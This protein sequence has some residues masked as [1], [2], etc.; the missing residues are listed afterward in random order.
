MRVEAYLSFEGRCEEALEFYQKAIGA[1]V[2]MMMRMNEN[3]EPDAHRAV[4]PGAEKK[5]LHAGFKVG[6]TLLM[7]SDG[8]CAGTANFDG[9]ALAITAKDDAEAKRLFDNLAAGGQV[10]QPLI[11]TFFSS[12]F[13]MVADRFGVPWMVVVDQ[14]M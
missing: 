12:S 13:G 8:E 4:P 11:K 1:E 6:D 5:V 3:P 7:A 10:R 14:P 9:I 2:L